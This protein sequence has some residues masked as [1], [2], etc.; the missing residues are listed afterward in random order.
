MATTKAQT[1]RIDT[2]K[3]VR[4]AP[5][6]FLDLP[7]ELRQMILLLVE[8]CPEHA[9]LSILETKQFID[10]WSKD[11]TE[12][13]DVV[14]H[15]IQYWRRIKMGALENECWARYTL[16]IAWLERT[17]NS[18]MSYRPRVSETMYQNRG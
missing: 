17:L 4:K 8:P 6:N 18:T 2:Q 7:P 3:T 11:M 1:K 5:T 13:R 10:T 16:S 9:S 15:D 14:F 12:I